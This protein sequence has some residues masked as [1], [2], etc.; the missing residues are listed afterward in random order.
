MDAKALKE[1]L[2]TVELFAD[3][4]K[5]AIATIA[6]SGRA[7]KHA[8]GHEVIAEGAGAVG[9]HLI[10]AGTAKVTSGGAVRRTLGVGDHFGEISVIDGQPRSASVE[11]VEGLETFMVHPSAIRTLIDENPKFARQ[12]L[13]LLCRR[14]R[15]A[16]SR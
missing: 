13:L 6:N 5:R 2:A 9:F 10:T 11:A 8:D 7:I 15:E 12:L 1:Q 14:L 16:E 3:L 4:P